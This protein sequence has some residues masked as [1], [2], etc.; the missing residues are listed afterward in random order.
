MPLDEESALLLPK[1][2]GAFALTMPAS[3]AKADRKTVS[4]R[5][6]NFFRKPQAQP[7]PDNAHLLGLLPEDVLGVVAAQFDPTK[8]EGVRGLL[9]LARQHSRYLNYLSDGDNALYPGLK[10]FIKL[11]DDIER[12]VHDFLARYPQWLQRDINLYRGIVIPYCSS[13]KHRDDVLTIPQLI[14]REWGSD[15]KID[16]LGADNFLALRDSFPL[17]C[18][19]N[20]DCCGPRVG[21]LCFLIFVGLPLLLTFLFLPR[22]LRFCGTDIDDCYSYELDTCFCDDLF[23]E[24]CGT[25]PPY[26]AGICDLYQRSYCPSGSLAHLIWDSPPPSWA[27]Y[28]IPSSIFVSCTYISQVGLLV[29]CSLFALAFLC[30]L[31]AICQHESINA[32]AVDGSLLFSKVKSASLFFAAGPPHRGSSLPA[33]PFLTRNPKAAL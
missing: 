16:I 21:L 30:C 10:R 2:E 15:E 33:Q 6:L 24:A 11:H 28:N 19:A 20:S 29:G 5:F 18:D 9:S 8:P 4:S 23:S 12:F 26:L 22:T 31:C 32:V 13:Q 25:S 3:S 7:E 1:P 17:G 27:V 14:M